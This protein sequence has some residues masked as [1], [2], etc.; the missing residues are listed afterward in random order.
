VFSSTEILLP[1]FPDSKRYIELEGCNEKA[2]RVVF[3]NF[4]VGVDKVIH[5]EGLLYSFSSYKKTLTVTT[6]TSH[7]KTMS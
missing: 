6:G 5:N 7:F 2:G 3:T 1:T 4:C